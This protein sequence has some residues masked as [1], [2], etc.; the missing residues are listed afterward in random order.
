MYRWLDAP[1]TPMCIL[2]PKNG[3]NFIG[4]TWKGNS[5]IKLYHITPLDLTTRQHCPQVFIPL[6][7]AECTAI[8]P[9][10]LSTASRLVKEVTNWTKLVQ[11][12]HKTA[13]S[14]MKTTTNSAWWWREYTPIIYH[15]AALHG[16]LWCK[17][18]W[19]MELLNATNFQLS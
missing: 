7:F 13:S 17:L 5:E 10:K 15:P 16:G 1:H 19:A 14:P 4:I 2:S 11:L 9:Q 3:L 12:S 8:L 6:R 18:C